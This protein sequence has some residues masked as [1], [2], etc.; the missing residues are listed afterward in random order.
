MCTPKN[1]KCLVCPVTKHCEALKKGTQLDRPVKEKKQPT[2]HYDIGV[3]VIWKDDKVLIQKR[4]KEGLLGGLWEFPGGKQEPNETL[5][6]TVTRE[7]DEELEL[8]VAVKDRIASVKH[9]YSHFKITLHAYHCLWVSG[10]PKPKAC[11]E[12]QWVTLEE[13]ENYAFPKANKKVLQILLT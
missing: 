4:P 13:L 5:E 7:I 10:I 1:P 9:A 3:G 12:W 11:D 2:P 6:N 8:K